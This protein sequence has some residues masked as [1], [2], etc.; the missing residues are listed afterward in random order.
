MHKHWFA[1]SSRLLC[2]AAIALSGLAR[3]Q[4]VAPPPDSS[5]ELSL[6]LGYGQGLGSVAAGVPRLQEF[7]NAGGSFTIDTGWRFDPR[8][9]VG[10]YGEVGTFDG[11]SMRNAD[12]ANTVA[13]GLQ[14][15]Y[16]VLPGRKY[17]PWLGVGFGWR[18]YFAD[19]SLLGTHKLQGLDLA[20]LRLGLDYRV[21]PAVALGP[22]FGITLT[23]FISEK[24]PGGDSY[25]DTSDRKLNTFVFAGL[26]GRFDM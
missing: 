3:G 9:M 23:D 1:R 10:V 22:V 18:G 16:H 2:V 26:Q 5:F 21:S 7:G 13:A 12:H 17:D 24:R 6:G 20:R 15:Q 19:R 11:G 25:S 14:G 8:F 4:E